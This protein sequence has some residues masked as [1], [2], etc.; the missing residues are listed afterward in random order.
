MTHEITTETL[1]AR[2]PKGVTISE[3][4]GYQIVDKGDC[5][6]VLRGAD[7]IG[8]A[9]LIDEAKALADADIEKRK[10]AETTCALITTYRS[11]AI[12]EAARVNGISVGV[13][14]YFYGAFIFNAPNVA[15]AKSRIDYAIAT[16]SETLADFPQVPVATAFN[17]LSA[18]ERKA[19]NLK[20][21]GRHEN[22]PNDLI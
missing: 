7:Y 15:Q 9:N 8:G 12:R 16:D 19:A 18:A 4:R 5:Y 17:T 22:N 1:A 11:Y 13:D 2:A 6:Q 20:K 21:M 14:V 3:Y 10:A